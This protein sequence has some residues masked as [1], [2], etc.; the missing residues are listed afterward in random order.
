MCMCSSVHFKLIAAA[1]TGGIVKTNFTCSFV[2]FKSETI[3]RTYSY[4]DTGF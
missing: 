4:S 2:N 3:L 1:Y